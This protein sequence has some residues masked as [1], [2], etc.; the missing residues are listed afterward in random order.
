MYLQIIISYLSLWTQRAM[1]PP[2][3]CNH[4]LLQNCNSLSQIILSH[5]QFVASTREAGKCGRDLVGDKGRAGLLN[6]IGF[7]IGKSSW[8]GL[9]EAIRWQ[10][11]Y[12]QHRGFLFLSLS[13]CSHTAS[14]PEPLSSHST[15]QPALSEGFLWDPE[16][17]RFLSSS[18]SCCSLL[19]GK[20]AGGDTRGCPWRFLGGFASFFSG[21]E[22]GW[23]V[24]FPLPSH[25]QRVICYLLHPAP[26]SSSCSH[27]H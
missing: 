14:G 12:R 21:V 6:N 8:E 17:T 2:T 22:A 20:M 27:Y 11:I 1:S 3:S 15:V 10:Q 13:Q 5:F 18:S 19:V 16:R 7:Q 9:W 4:Y 26:L 24:L 25:R 23:W